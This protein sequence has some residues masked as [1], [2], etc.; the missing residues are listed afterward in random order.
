MLR[1]RS[2]ESNLAIRVRSS[3]FTEPEVCPSYPAARSSGTN[4][5]SMGQDCGK[6]AHSKLGT[7]L[8]SDRARRF[9]RLP[10]SALS[11]VGPNDPTAAPV[12]DDLYHFV[13]PPGAVWASPLSI[14]VDLCDVVVRAATLLAETLNFLAHT[15]R[16]GGLPALAA[17]SVMYLGALSLAVFVPF[18]AALRRQEPGG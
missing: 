18:C 3:V 7:A 13:L 14:R 17:R 15:A 9:L 16:W 11:W 12:A 10:I 4:V 5:I 2:P 6:A 1:E 8:R